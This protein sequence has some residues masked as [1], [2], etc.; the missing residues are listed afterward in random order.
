[1]SS[2]VGHWCEPRGVQKAPR[3]LL[4]PVHAGKDYEGRKKDLTSTVRQK[5][6]PSFGTSVVLPCLCTVCRAVQRGDYSEETFWVSVERGCCHS[7]GFSWE[8]KS[9]SALD[10]L[11]QIE[12]VLSLGIKSW[13]MQIWNIWLSCSLFLQI[14]FLKKWNDRAKQEFIWGNLK[15]MTKCPMCKKEGKKE[16]KGMFLLVSETFRYHTKWSTPLNDFVKQC[17]FCML[18]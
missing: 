14:W 4:L 2:F 1:M 8:T 7:K 9:G 10:E 11:A 16:N 18:G 6:C 3:R 5:V 15:E 13:F 17:S 12:S